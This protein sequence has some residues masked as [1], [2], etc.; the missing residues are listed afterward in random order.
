MMTAISKF[1]VLL[2][3]YSCHSHCSVAAEDIFW[4]PIAR[5][6]SDLPAKQARIVNG[7]KSN[8]SNRSFFAKAGYDEYSFTNEIL[9]GATVIWSD[10]LIT[11][12]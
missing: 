5:I 12:A 4:D 3:I 9:C 10:I 8:P 7:E 2:A 11:A 6:P 1:F